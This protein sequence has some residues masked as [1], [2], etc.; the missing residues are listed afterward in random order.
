MKTSATC[1]CFKC[2]FDLDL[3]LFLRDLFDDNDERFAELL[4]N[5]QE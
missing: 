5:C 2:V 3:N 4:S 1:Y